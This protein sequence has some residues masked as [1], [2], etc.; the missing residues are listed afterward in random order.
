MY[1]LLANL[2]IILKSTSVKEEE[3]V[4][5]WMKFLANGVNEK[6]LN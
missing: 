4:R 1:G 2:K 5:A 3:C 6:E